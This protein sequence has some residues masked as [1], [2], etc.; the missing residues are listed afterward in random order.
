MQKSLPIFRYWPVLYLV[1]SIGFVIFSYTQ[2]DLNLTLTAGNIWGNIQS[3]LQHIG[4]FQRPLATGLYLI[5]ITLFYGLYI[6]S[7]VLIKRGA[8]RSRQIILTVLIVCL[9]LI[10]A[11]PAFSYDIFNY[12]FTAKTV[13]LYQKNPYLVTPLAFTGFDP[14]LSFLRWTHL[15]SAYT[16]L[17]ILMT[18]PSYLF[19]F[20]KF[21]LIMFNF[22]LL[23]AS[24]YL[25]SV[26]CLWYAFK[27]IQPRQVLFNTAVFALNPLVLIE[28]VFSPHNDI[29]MVAFFCLSFWLYTRRAQML[30]VLALSVS[31]AIKLMTV[32][33]FPAYFYKWSRKSVLFFMCLA[34]LVGFIRKELLP[35]YFLWIMPAVSINAQTRVVLF[36]STLFSLALL[37]RY[38]P[39]LYFGEYSRI[40]LISRDGLTVLVILVGIIV[41]ACV[42]S[43][44][45]PQ[46][47]TQN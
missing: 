27:N 13:L 38:I 7:L 40:A 10:F 11:Y 1:V 2:V 42:T 29:A 14:W 36:L 6:A 33:V 35:W 21:F 12:M 23:M 39:I 16:P 41:Y 34:M 47:S 45:K 44:I 24:F 25:L 5:F 17:W 18:L 15:V 8:L 37:V 28:S 32:F 9:C 20:G 19:G 3:Y 30:S 22:K 46:K 43:R 4:Y 26:C 31:V